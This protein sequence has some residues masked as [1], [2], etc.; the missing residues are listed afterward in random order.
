MSKAEILAELPKLS[1]K[2]LAEVQAKL[3]ELTRDDWLNDGELSDADKG[4]LD[5]ALAEYQK[6]PDAGST[7]QEV[8][9][10]IRSRFSK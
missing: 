9:A 1:A 6:N 8:E 4:L 5:A 3:D 2:E 10:R 7:W